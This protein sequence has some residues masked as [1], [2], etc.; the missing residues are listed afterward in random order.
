MLVEEHEVEDRLLPGTLVGAHLVVRSVLGRGGTAVVYEAVH[1]RLSALVA[2][3]VLEVPEPYR[4]DAA[5]R[6]QREA[7]VCASLDDP[8]VP[9]VH[10]V[11]ALPDG[12]P[13]VVME[14][15]LG[16]TLEQLLAQ[17]RLRMPVV[18]AVADDLLAALEAVHRA[19]VVHRDIKPANLIIKFGQ[20]G[21]AHVRLMDFGISKSVCREPADLKLTRVGTVI[22]TPHYMAP[23]QITGDQV[24]ARADI[25]ATGV[26]LFEMLTGRTPYQGETT[27]E[28]VAA[29]LRHDERAFCSF[30]SHVPA[31]VQAVVL[32]A[33]AAKPGD[34]FMTVRDMRAA[35][36]E[37]LLPEPEPSSVQ[38]HSLTRVIQRR[39]WPMWGAGAIIVSS[40]A[41]P[42]SVARESSFHHAGP[43]PSTA[44]GARPVQ[45]LP[46]LPGLPHLGRLEL[47]WPEPKPPA[48]PVAEP[49]KTSPDVKR[50]AVAEPRE[51]TTRS[52]SREPEASKPAPSGVLISDYLQKL[53]AL[54]REATEPAPV[55]PEAHP[56]E[57]QRSSERVEGLPDNPY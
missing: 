25:Y 40:F 51:R 19:G 23:E 9:R 55:V 49:P 26:V 3:K 53:D 36:T 27:A 39:H 2:L 35:L 12:T 1:T 21:S 52:L 6:L 33:M 11:G 48:E 4:E 57:R 32:R 50:T 44:G 30:F 20:D 47:H 14:K 46:E 10:D 31:R 15:V 16:T 5:R 41:W 24:D 37:A 29:V 17:G 56:G 34:R 42:G 8:H 13:Y 45:P 7:E 54:Q 18:L 43:K 28:V 22:G 38:R